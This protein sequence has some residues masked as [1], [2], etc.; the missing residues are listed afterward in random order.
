CA[1][2]SPIFL[3]IAS[4]G[5]ELGPKA[6]T[7]DPDKIWPIVQA[8]EPKKVGTVQTPLLKA[9]AEAGS[10]PA[11]ATPIKNCPL[12]HFRGKKLSFFALNVKN[13]SDQVAII[14]GDSA[15][16][17]LPAGLA[18]TTPASALIRGASQ[19]LTPKGKLLLGAATA[20][21]LG[22]AGIILLENM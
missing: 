20:G 12:C 1:L 8:P 21:S 10:L 13:L 2:I 11:A 3:T 4:W 14:D 18:G 7:S 17:E 15:Q 5:S 22:L 6:A 9:V 16:A 19:N